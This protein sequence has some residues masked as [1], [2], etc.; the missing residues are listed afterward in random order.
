MSIN[1][2]PLLQAE[3]IEV[4]PGI[5]NDK[6]MTLLLYINS[7]SAMRILDEAVGPE[8][9]QREHESINGSIY[10]SVSIWSED[11]KSW[12]K[13]QDVGSASMAEAEK[14]MASDS[15]KRSCVSWGLGRALYGCGLLWLKS[16]LY[17]AEKKNERWVVKDSFHVDEILY[18][19]QGEIIS[20][21]IK[22]QNEEIVLNKKIHR[23]RSKQPD[24]QITI[25][26]LS[27]LMEQMLSVG[28]SMQQILDRYSLTDITQMT[29]NHYLKAM[30]SLKATQVKNVA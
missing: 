30:R 20:I 6:G 24:M 12:V 19:N 4:R 11:K 29:H 21:T 22:N 1:N 16:D 3:D 17:S 18:D 10:C 15:F 23:K 7:R 14:G 28:V 2:M 8:N 5:V 13:K 9:W 27:A 25:E 26:E